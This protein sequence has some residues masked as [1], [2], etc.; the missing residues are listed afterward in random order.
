M[1]LLKSKE[2]TEPVI[3]QTKQK[4][5]RLAIPDPE[6]TLKTINRQE[7]VTITNKFT[8]KNNPIRLIIYP[9]K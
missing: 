7:T 4:A 2:I 3:P 5:A 8:I 9:H 6:P 1:I